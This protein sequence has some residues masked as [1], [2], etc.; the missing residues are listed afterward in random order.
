M[1]GVIL[2]RRLVLGGLSLAVLCSLFF[3]PPMAL[4]AP[5]PL[6]P[7]AR[8]YDP[9]PPAP[10]G[11]VSAA[12]DLPL[13]LYIPLL[14]NC[15]CTPA[16]IYGYVTKA[17]VPIGN[18][19]I[20]LK[21]RDQTG[22]HDFLTTSTNSCGFY[23]FKDVPGINSGSGQGYFVEFDNNVL[24]IIPNTLRQWQTPAVQ[25]YSTGQVFNIG[26]FDIG[27][28]V[29]GE[30]NNGTRRTLPIT[31]YWTK[32]SQAPSD[33]YIFYIYEIIR[34]D[35]N[36]PTYIIKYY[37]DP[38]G[39]V[40]S[41]QLFKSQLPADLVS[42]KLYYWYLTIIGPMG[43]TGRGGTMHAVAFQLP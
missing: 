3:F 38:L 34:N 39:Y 36:P 18:V 22:E 16:G 4:A 33:S 43:S 11:P 12:R 24:P 29:L 8:P 6:P 30:P 41:Y 25:S 15:Y 17:G 1:H 26:N 21:L 7:A 27:D 5:G 9:P 13:R 31:F 37:T 23:S 19:T 42:G 10:D 28:V 35:P 40:G 32:R 20:F 14:A 2:N